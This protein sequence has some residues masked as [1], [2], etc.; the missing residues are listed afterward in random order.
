MYYD[1]C[2]RKDIFVFRLSLTSLLCYF[3]FALQLNTEKEDL[4]LE[5]VITPNNWFSSKH[6]KPYT[7]WQ[8][9]LGKYIKYT[10]MYKT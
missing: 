9:H 10:E 8:L 3:M 7:K 1:F 4:S 5:S 2:K 6:L